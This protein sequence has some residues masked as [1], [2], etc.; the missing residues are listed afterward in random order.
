[1]KRFAF[2][3]VFISFQV[4]SQIDNEFLLT[5]PITPKERLN[6]EMQLQDSLMHNIGKYNIDL[7]ISKISSKQFE[8]E[9]GFFLVEDLVQNSETGENDYRITYLYNMNKN[10]TSEVRS[11]WDKGNSIWIYDTRI[12]NKYDNNNHIEMSY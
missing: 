1:M 11:D 8:L 9:N 12:L 4:I 2:I 5:K 10:M 6:A 7:K 3:L